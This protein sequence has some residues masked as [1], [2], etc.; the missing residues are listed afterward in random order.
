ME[1]TITLPGN[2]SYYLQ[3]STLTPA[4]VAGPQAYVLEN[5]VTFKMFNEPQNFRRWFAEGHAQE[6]FIP[7]KN[8]DLPAA[9]G[10][11]GAIHKQTGETFA[12]LSLSPLAKSQLAVHAHAATIRLIYPDFSVKNQPYTYRTAYFFGK[13]T[14][15]EIQELYQRLRS[16]K[17]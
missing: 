17:E 10:F 5:S 13:A 8:A 1:H 7:E 14:G 4:E 6:E 11:I 15:E 2:A 12:L 16:G 9:S 3:T